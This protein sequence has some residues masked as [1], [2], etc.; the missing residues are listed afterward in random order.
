MNN[1]ENN[2]LSMVEEMLKTED[3][4]FNEWEIEFLGSVKKQAYFSDKQADCI[5][6]IYKRRMK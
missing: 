4:G 1:E 6:R 3:A 5:E 2:L